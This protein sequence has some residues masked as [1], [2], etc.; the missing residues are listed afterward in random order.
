MSPAAGRRAGGAGRRAGWPGG[1]AIVA[2]HIALALGC[3]TAETP[4]APGVVGDARQDARTDAASA[5]DIGCRPV[6]VPYR[7]DV[8]PLRLPCAPTKE[9]CNGVDDDQDGIT[10]PH[11]PSVPCRSDDDCTLGG[12]I[13]DADCNFNPDPPYVGPPFCSPID[14]FPYSGDAPHAC[15]GML[16]PPGTKCTLGECVTPGAG[17]PNSLCTTGRD[18]PIVSGCIPEHFGEES[19]GRCLQYCQDSACP[20]GYFCVRERLGSGPEVQATCVGALFCPGALDVCGALLATCA[21]AGTCGELLACA[22]DGCFWSDSLEACDRG[23]L[24]ATYAAPESNALAQCIRKACP[25]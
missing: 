14:G 1:S 21:P 2:A 15:R 7:P 16:C 11:C 22:D 12:L 25:E 4:A 9:P 6:D 18:C 10:D 13:P 19:R 20:E 17:L 8:D 24:S 5:P 3:A 23:C